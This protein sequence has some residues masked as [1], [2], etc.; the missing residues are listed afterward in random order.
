MA[1]STRPAEWPTH[2]RLRLVDAVP[3]VAGVAVF[4]DDAQAVLVQEGVG[5]AHDVGVAHPAQ[6]LDLVLAGLL[7]LRRDVL[8]LDH[9]ELNWQRG[10]RCRYGCTSYVRYTLGQ[11]SL[12]KGYNWRAKEGKYIDAQSYAPM[13]RLCACIR[14]STWSFKTQRVTLVDSTVSAFRPSRPPHP[15]PRCTAV[16]AA[17]S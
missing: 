17:V 11:F 10:D 3:E 12:N 1:V 5:V 16:V 6:E 4:H 15:L 9:L 14:G 2:T 13:I 7:L 8:E